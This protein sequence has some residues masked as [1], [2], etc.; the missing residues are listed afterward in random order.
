MTDCTICGTA[1]TSEPDPVAHVKDCPRCGRWQ[2][3]APKKTQRSYQ[4]ALSGYANQELARTNLSHKVRR[5]GRE[6]MHVGV[7]IDDLPAWGLNDPLPRPMQQ[8]DDLILYVG[9]QLPT[10]AH[11]VPVDD[12]LM[13]AW[14]GTT[15]SERDPA[16]GLKWLLNQ[17]Q[18]KR[19]VIA[20]P[21]G[22]RHVYRLTWAGWERYEDLMREEVT[23]RVAFMAMQ[24]G[25]TELNAAVASCFKPAVA[26]T[27]FTLKLLT[28]DQGAGCIDDQMRVAI[29]TSRLMLADLTH[30]N[31]G[32]YW[33]GGFA[34]GLGKPVIYTCKK[35]VW[36]KEKTHFDTNHLVTIIWDPANLPKAAAE[37][38]ATIRATLPDVAKL[39]D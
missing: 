12:L 14:L 2:F 15:I 19:W 28:D 1:L 33:E 36:D 27:G 31:P 9:Q 32:A 10:A 5:M 23:S 39:T 29:R 4:E 7:P 38:K 20:Q 37:L 17:D 8:V 30:R 22:G 35:A 18:L 6:G 25:D 26:E 24:F 16:V 3:L 11:Q 21:S 34:E 13:C